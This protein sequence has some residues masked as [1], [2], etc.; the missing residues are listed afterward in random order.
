MK[1]K[2]AFA[3]KFDQ[4]EIKIPKGWA[5]T[6]AKDAKLAR[7][8][9]LY[10]IAKRLKRHSNFP[11]WRKNKEEIAKVIGVSSF[12]LCNYVRELKNLGLCWELNGTLYLLGLRKAQIL[13]KG[14]SCKENKQRVHYAPMMQY[15]AFKGHFRGMCVF[16]H[17][18]RQAWK[19]AT[20]ATTRENRLPRGEFKKVLAD[21]VLS[22]SLTK[23]ASY[24]G[25]KSASTGMKT[26]DVIVGQNFGIFRELENS[27]KISNA[28][29]YYNDVN[30]S[31]KPYYLHKGTL[32]K[33]ESYKYKI[34]QTPL[35]L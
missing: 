11:E 7:H 31:I 34:P 17:L 28:Y 1:L 13:F 14:D 16:E 10:L 9:G 8:L 32:Y 3:T 20:Q 2:S 26:S 35:S 27:K 4:T 15:N 29:Y 21:Q 18:Q 22:L 5:T 23:M 6:F 30:N 25:R 12:T 33:R 19:S 24:F